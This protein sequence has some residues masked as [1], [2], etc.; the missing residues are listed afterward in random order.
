MSTAEEPHIFILLSTTFIDIRHNI[1]PA[2]CLHNIPKQRR[3]I[4][5][6]RQLLIRILPTNLLLGHPA[7]LAIQPAVVQVQD[8]DGNDA[9]DGKRERA[10]KARRVRRRLGRDVDV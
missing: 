4:A 3:L 9:R 10:S 8:N 7:P 1:I 2:G 5:H 6:T